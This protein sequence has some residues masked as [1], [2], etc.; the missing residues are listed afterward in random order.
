MEKLN[1][2]WIQGLTCGGNTQS[3][4]CAE[5]TLLNTFL[6]KVNLLVHPGLSLDEDLEKTVE[7]VLKGDVRLDILAVEGAVRERGKGLYTVLDMRFD[8]VLRKLCGVANYVI[9][10]GNCAAYGN[11][12]ALKEGSVKGLQFRFTERGGFL[13]DGFRSKS[14]LPV[15]NLTGC[16]VHPEWFIST[17]LQIASG[18]PPKLDSLGRPKEFYTYFTHDGCLRNQYYEWR[19]EAEVLG[20]KEG[21]LFYRFGCRGPMTRSSCNRILWNGVS[22]KTRSGQPC[23]GCTEFDFPRENIWETK[24]NM[25]IPAELPPGVSLRGYIMM[26]GVAKTFT[27]DRLRRR[28]LDEDD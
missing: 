11:I 17:V 22:S 14:G 13:G 5:E 8:E 25:G 23:F 4:L 19:V 9:A 3:L 10:V 21:C 26:S 1:L 15:I 16:P 12:P 27:P 6:K 20:R 2:L 7:A 24:Y 28:L 18:R